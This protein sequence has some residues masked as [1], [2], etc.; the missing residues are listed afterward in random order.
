[1]DTSGIIQA[2]EFSAL[3]FNGS[4]FFICYSDG[5]FESKYIFAAKEP[6]TGSLIAKL[7]SCFM[8]Y[9]LYVILLVVTNNFVFTSF[10]THLGGFLVC[11]MSSKH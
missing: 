11:L 5:E 1:M 8:V 9:S 6:I 7:Q 3:I 2:Q 4:K 10:L